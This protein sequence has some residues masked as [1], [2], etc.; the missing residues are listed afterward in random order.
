MLE[1]AVEIDVDDLAPVERAGP[2]EGRVDGADPRV[3]HENVQSPVVRQ[4]GLT[5]GQDLLLPAH[6]RHVSRHVGALDREF[7]GRPDQ[8]LLS[9]TR[10]R[11]AGTP[12]R[13]ARSDRLSYAAARARD[14][15]DLAGEIEGIPLCHRTSPPE[16]GYHQLG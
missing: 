9:A 15:C 8:R 4:H 3:V 6:V 14:E 10:Q 11:Y 12:R 7:L 1:H 13:Q 16:A 5:Q 2:L